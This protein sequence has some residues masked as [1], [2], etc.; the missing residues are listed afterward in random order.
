LPAALREKPPCE[1]VR[2]FCSKHGLPYRTL[3]WGEA[4]WKSYRVFFFPK[5]V[6]ADVNTLRLSD[7]SA[8][9]VTRAAEAARAKT[10][11]GTA[12]Q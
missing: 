7:G 10:G 5:P 9:S 2:E 4:L 11:G 6:I 1:A 8:P 3:G 12:A